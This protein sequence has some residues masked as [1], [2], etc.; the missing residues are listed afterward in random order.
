MANVHNWW[1]RFCCNIATQASVSNLS[2]PLAHG[3]GLRDTSFTVL[4]TVTNAGKVAGSV[5]VMVAFE[6]QTR[7]VVRYLR[8]LAGYVLMTT[9][10]T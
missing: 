10:L 8:Q 4:V 7:M 5:P 6:K 3:L 1:L 9:I 2:K